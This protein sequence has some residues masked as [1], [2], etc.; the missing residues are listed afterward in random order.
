MWWEFNFALIQTVTKWLVQNFAHETTPA[1]YYGGMCKILLPCHHNEFLYHMNCDGKTVSEKGKGPI[2]LT[3]FPSQFKC[4]HVATKFCPCCAVVLC[5][6][7]CSYNCISIWVRAKRN[8]HHILIVMSKLLVKWALELLIS[9]S[10]VNFLTSLLRSH[11]TH[12]LSI[13]HDR[14]HWNIYILYDIYIIHHVSPAGT[15]A[16]C[17]RTVHDHQAMFS[18]FYLVTRIYLAV[19]PPFEGKRLTE[20]F[21]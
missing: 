16:T 6:N 21:A 18:E 1:Q 3:I 15:G 8:S 5:A 10:V 14:I 9:W 13:I 4:D 20:N 17:V 2:G 12:R 19:C 11:Q 7:F